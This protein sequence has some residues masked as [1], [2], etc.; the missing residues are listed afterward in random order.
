MFAYALAALLLQ[1][2]APSQELRIEV[3]KA[4]RELVLYS[5]AR[6]LKTYRIGLGFAPARRK[7]RQGDG[8]TPEGRYV[9]CRKN[10]ASRFYLSLG[11]SYPNGEDAERGLAAGLIS[12]A[13]HRRIR[14]ALASGGCPPWNTRLGGEIFIHGNGSN[15]DWTL[16]CIALDD[17]DMKDLYQSVPVG[18]PVTIHP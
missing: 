1:P 16:G 13:Q 15:S 5:G 3:F 2:A 6:L 4:R 18:T 11:L 14:D 9:V 7:S 17:T 12:R 8:G 10:P